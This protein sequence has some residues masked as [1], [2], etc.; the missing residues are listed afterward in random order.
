[1]G[2]T[3]TIAYVNKFTLAHDV[4]NSLGPQL[5]Y[6]PHTRAIPYLIGIAA[7]Y[8]TNTLNR[9]LLIGK[10]SIKICW[11]ISIFSAILS[12]LLTTFRHI[13][14]D[15]AAPLLPVFRILYGCSITWMIVSSACGHGG[16]LAR[17]LNLKAF[18][19]FGKLTFA[20]Y[21]VHPT[22]I[23]I[24]FNSRDESTHADPV[25]MVCIRL[26]A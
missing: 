16:L 6:A 18:R 9:K 20:I 21:L 14:Y 19:H 1:M 4:H 22:I 8:V 3:Y 23:M 5:Y 2:I 25:L 10:F 24:I 13:S 17:I 26:L 11:A 12:H 7:G 15:F